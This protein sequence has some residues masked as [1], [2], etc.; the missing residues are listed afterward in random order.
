MQQKPVGNILTN[1]FT[2]LARLLKKLNTRKTETIDM[3]LVIAQ[4]EEI[5]HGSELEL[6]FDS[7]Y[8]EYSLR[9]KL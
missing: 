3:P 6:R 2:D 9:E 4:I 5:L 7:E 8:D 1:R